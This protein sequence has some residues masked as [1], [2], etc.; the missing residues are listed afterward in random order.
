M[1]ISTRMTCTLALIAMLTVGRAYAICAFDTG[2]FGSAMQVGPDTWTYD[3]SV[4][5]GCDFENQPFMNDF[6]IPYFNDAGITDITVP[7]PDTTSTTSTITWSDT[8][9][10]N[11]NLFDLPGAGVIDFHVTATP[12]LQGSSG[13]NAPGVG[14]YGASG[15]TFTA[16]FAPVEGPGAVL[17]YLPPDYSTTTIVFAD[18]PIPASPETIAALGSTATPEPAFAGLTAVGLSGI[19]ILARKRQCGSARRARSAAG[20]G[21]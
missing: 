7:P 15:F 14:Y 12:E 4:I 1:K 5:N 18:P 10:A 16:N 20:G 6:Y 3:L 8:I 9:L 11:D 2:V 17:Q 21:V 13:Q 19:L